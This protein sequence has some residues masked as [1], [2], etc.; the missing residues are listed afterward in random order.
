MNDTNL[1]R[2][3]SVD[4]IEVFLKINDNFFDRFSKNESNTLRPDELQKFLQIQRK[5]YYQKYSPSDKGSRHRLI[6]PFS[7]TRAIDLI[8]SL[9]RIKFDTFTDKYFYRIQKVKEISFF[10]A[11][12]KDTIEQ[13]SLFKLINYSERDGSQSQEFQNLYKLIES[14][15]IPIADT[16]KEKDI[17]IWNN[18]IIALKKLVKEKEQIWKVT[19]VSKPYYVNK[20]NSDERESLIEIY[21]DE[22][23]LLRN[24]ER[25]FK[26]L[27]NDSEIEEYSFEES[28][29]FVE[30]K[31]FTILDELTLTNLKN[32][33][34]EIFYD[35]KD[36]TPIH[37]ISGNFDFIYGDFEDKEKVYKDL[38]EKF[39]DEYNL[40]LNIQEEGIV[41]MNDA[42]EKHFQ[43]FILD[44]YNKILTLNQDKNTELLVDFH[45]INQV[46]F[47]EKD[48][49]EKLRTNGY[50]RAI[51]NILEK[52]NKLKI[53][54][55]KFLRTDFFSDFGIKFEKNISRFYTNQ[56]LILEDFPGLIKVGKEYHFENASKNDIETLNKIAKEKYSNLEFNRLPSIFIFEYPKEKNFE[57]L[58]DFKTLTDIPQKS[59]FNINSSILTIIA[60]DKYSFANELARIKEVADFAILENKV[61]EK[62]MKL[63][64][65]GDNEENRSII[66]NSLQNELR[67]SI[68][69]GIVF[70]TFKKNSSLVFNKNFKTEKEREILL[71]NLH[72]VAEKYRDVLRLHINSKLG[73]STYDFIKNESLE[74]ENQKEL[75]KDVRFQTF[76]F[77]SPEEKRQLEESIQN[78][79]I[80]AKFY[81]GLQ[82]GKLV[83]KE[84]NKLTFKLTD[85]FEVKLNAKIDERL[86]LSEVKDGFVKPIFPGELTNIDRML[87]AMRKVTMPGGKIG[88]PVNHNLSNFLF[89][90]N[91]VRSS[92]ND[93]EKV[94]EKI[95][96]NLN[97]PLL[98]NQNKQVE[99][100]AKTLLAKDM[101][102]IQGPPG[103]GKTT[104]I[105]EIIWQTLS[106]NPKAKILITSQTN[107]AVDNALERLKGKK[108]VR[109][110][111][112]G[113]N[114]KF[115]D[116]GK[117]YSY[118]RIYE[119][120]VSKK[121]SENEKYNQDNAVNNWIDNVRKSCSSELKFSKGLDKWRTLLEEKDSII[122]TMFTEN[123]H[124]N[125]N[126][127]AA[128]C[129]ECGSNRFSEV[130]KTAFS[131]NS[132][133]L[134]EPDFDI[135]IMDEASKA[136]PPELVLPLTFGKKVVI[137][138]D[139]KQL[140]PM[141]DEKEFSEALESIGAKKLIEDWTSKDY[142]TS[143]FEK[144]FR[145]APKSIV[146]SLDTQFRMHEQIMNCISQFYEDQDELENGLLCGIKK[147]MD[148]PNFAN[149]ASR[150]H[151]LS[152][153]P[154][155][156]PNNH[157][158]WINVD[159]DEKKVGTSYENP[160][161]V[162]AIHIVL[163]AL[164]RSVGFSSYM[165]NCIK[166]ED[167]EIGIIT[168]YMPQMQAIKSS[169]YKDL[170]KHQLRNFEHFKNINEY[171]L[172]FRIN[173]VDRFQGMERNIVIIS[174]VRSNKQVTMDQ[175]KVRIRNNTSLGFAKEFQRINVGFSRAK[176]LLIVI[177]NQKHFSQKKE[178]ETAISKMHKI[179]ISQLKNVIE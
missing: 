62:K 36:D 156:S 61:F 154:L 123:Y 112:I 158:I 69:E 60:D 68:P 24:L 52:E 128:T 113:N 100:V 115:E 77:L 136:T 50:D 16:N 96:K 40:E 11:P 80:D 49:T 54:V 155:I 27:F 86:E 57:L 85:S 5:S 121:K 129:S 2:N 141:L 170:N 92:D 44:N 144:L 35:L 140:P 30:F 72:N 53:T 131:G 6:I 119:W 20:Q 18:Y 151:G 64:F 8:V 105:A 38:K 102:L 160:S 32:L 42:D 13:N 145:N 104:V 91:E 48:I 99:A 75:L 7:K 153:S 14:L 148:I 78:F 114:D 118:D 51:I 34:H 33:A 43:K 149:K 56:L 58:R 79:G 163:H 116:E 143:Q 45:N 90:P 146:T 31:K 83:K 117:V 10:N 17:R 81:G 159:S 108:L 97:E 175:N 138:G 74:L 94:K 25:N 71:K 87:K 95:L 47:K 1:A 37:T 150:W 122:K 142:S 67:R 98:R 4:A 139:H 107:L 19:D 41:I 167:R 152:V 15:N 169:I 12:K 137:I 21:I 147:E 176:R 161:E 165:D 179:D 3:I 29:V 111:R 59:I 130:Y 120:Q 46:D 171:Q 82:I 89:D 164:T 162:E 110:I 28:R 55:S 88:Y 103:T 134:F 127:F 174:T 66:L 109:P 65:F 135:V 70:Q 172:P 39:K 177:G 125:I 124:K 166:E 93:L 157:A 22:K 132:E 168:Y 101:A 173:T 106:E 178:Y 73:N 26:S 9:D 126:V 84:S 133:N 63:N 76:I 23:E